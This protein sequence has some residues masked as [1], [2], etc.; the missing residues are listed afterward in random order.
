M[1]NQDKYIIHCPKCGA[2]YTPS[3]IFYPKSVFV[4]VPD[5]VKNKEGKIVS[6]TGNLIKQDEKYICD[7]CNAPFIATIKLSVDTKVDALS[8][9]SEPYKTQIKHFDKLV[10]AEE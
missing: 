3:E 4:S 10:L 6:Y 5:V 1:R 9:F 2:E 7:V 8:D